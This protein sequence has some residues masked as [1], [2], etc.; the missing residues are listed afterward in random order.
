MPENQKPVYVSLVT[1]IW[2][3]APLTA[4]LCRL[5]QN[6]MLTL[7]GAINEAKQQPQLAGHTKKS[8]DILGTYLAETTGHLGTSVA[9]LRKA[10]KYL[11][12]LTNA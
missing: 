1:H 12:E 3:A 8:L 7:I 11:R 4:E 10:E 9:L 2:K 5:L 6:E